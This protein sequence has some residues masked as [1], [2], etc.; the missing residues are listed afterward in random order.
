[1]RLNHVASCV[2]QIAKQTPYVASGGP[3]EVLPSTLPQFLWVL[4][5]DPLLGWSGMAAGGIEVHQLPGHHYTYVADPAIAGISHAF[6]SSHIAKITQLLT[7]FLQKKL[8]QLFR[9][10]ATPAASGLTRALTRHMK[11][12]V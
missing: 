10:F 12:K 9:Q 5:V 2:G 1:M 7:K 3:S 6:S 11:S 8:V 4:R